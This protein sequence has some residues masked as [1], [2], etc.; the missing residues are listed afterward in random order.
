MRAMTFL[1]TLLVPA[2]ALASGGE[3]HGHGGPMT[4]HSLMEGEGGTTLLVA[5]INFVLLVFVLRKLMGGPL[6]S[7]LDGRRADIEVGMKEAAEM[8]AKA[9]AAF[10]EYSERLDSLD[11]EMNKLRQDIESAAEADKNRMMDDAKAEAARLKSETESLVS[12]HAATLGDAIKRDVVNAA[13]DAA[14][15][16]LRTAMGPEDQRRLADGYVE[17][18]QDGGAA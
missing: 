16:T 6:S 10:K 11:A 17:R 18:L 9:E 2:V 14:E 7:H 12:R 13:V 15:Q 4:L 1:M 8:K 5:A 3:A